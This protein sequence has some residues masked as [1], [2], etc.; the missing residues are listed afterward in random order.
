MSDNEIYD[1]GPMYPPPAREVNG[2]IVWSPGASKREVFAKDFVAAAITGR[3]ANPYYNGPDLEPCP[4]EK[5]W[6]YD[7]AI[8]MA[9]ALLAA[10]DKP[11]EEKGVAAPDRPDFGKMVRETADAMNRCYA[12]THGLTPPETPAKE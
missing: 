7:M 3:I 2:L 6:I 5:N 10:L 8:I 12:I 1:G 4:E 9:D 11:Q